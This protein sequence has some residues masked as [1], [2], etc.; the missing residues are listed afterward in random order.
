MMEA[1]LSNL[2]TKGVKGVHLGMAARN[3]RALAFYL[4]MGFSKLPGPSSP[5]DE[6]G[7]LYLGIT[8]Q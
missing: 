1:L 5:D 7:E 6:D 4:K 2:R 3:H 8:L